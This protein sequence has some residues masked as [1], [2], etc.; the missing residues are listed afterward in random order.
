MPSCMSKEAIKAVLKGI[1]AGRVDL[2]LFVEFTHEDFGAAG[3]AAIA[4]VNLWLTCQKE[5]VGAEFSTSPEVLRVFE[6]AC[7]HGKFGLTRAVYLTT[8]SG[9]Q[10][11]GALFA[12]VESGIVRRIDKI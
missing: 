6:K 8:E 3:D 5:H 2:N 1:P 7:K 10:P 4:L 12:A 11:D 9:Y